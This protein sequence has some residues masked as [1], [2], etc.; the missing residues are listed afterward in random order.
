MGMVSRDLYS[1]RLIPSGLSQ[2]LLTP[3]F[4]LHYHMHLQPREMTGDES[5]LSPAVSLVR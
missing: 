3:P 2:D 5:D 4:R 1:T